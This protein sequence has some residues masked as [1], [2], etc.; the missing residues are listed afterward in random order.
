[1]GE[2]V[3]HGATHSWVEVHIPGVSWVGFDSV[4]KRYPDV[5]HMRV[6]VGLCYKNTVFGT[7]TDAPGCR[8]YRD[9]CQG[10]SVPPSFR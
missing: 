5:R 6:A 7:R 10:L 4:D 3:E 8:E 1:M 2:K 9:G